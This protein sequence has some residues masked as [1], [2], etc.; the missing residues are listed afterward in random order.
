[1]SGT[2]GPGGSGVAREQGESGA[3]DR[4]WRVLHVAS[5]LSPAMGGS[6]VAA[7][8]LAEATRGGG[9]RCHVV[10]TT[11]PGSGS[12]VAFLERYRGLE[13]EAFPMCFP[14][15]S[16]NSRRLRGWLAAR[17]GGFDVVHIHGVFN[18]AY[19]Y[20]GWAALQAGVPLVISPHNSLD[21]YDLRKKA[22]LK[23]WIYG[24]WFVR[25]LLNR[26]AGVLCTTRLE[27]ERLVTY[28]ADCQ[29]RSAVIPL[30]VRAPGLKA[31]EGR[32]RERHGIGKESLVVLFLSRLD[33]KKGLPMLVE[34][35]GRVASSHPRAELVI[36]GTGDERVV[37]DARRRA[38][39]CGVEGRVRW[40][41]FVG[42]REK[43]EAFLGSDVFALPSYNENFGIVV[44]EAMYAGRPVLLSS[45]VYLSEDLVGQ[46][47]VLPCDPTV[48]SVAWGLDRLLGNPE[49][50]RRLGE[51]G[52]EVAARH[53]APELIGARMRAFYSGLSG[54]RRREDG[55]RMA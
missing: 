18:F 26:A 25:R 30:P 44:V 16:F 38:A 21:P 55:R 41:G 3:E 45:G 39:S 15:H 14:R 4:V 13:I 19:L 53:F 43:E 54:Q 17:V 24:P 29:G 11:V 22:V 32:W 27:A 2:Q 8:E 50:R 34:A 9:W 36:C 51:K 1:M 52:A 48:E 33:P 28:G 6:I 31:G 49:E 23:R 5:H 20:G 7:L 10:G 42:G 35:F 46:G 12:E 47:C 37:A 40:L